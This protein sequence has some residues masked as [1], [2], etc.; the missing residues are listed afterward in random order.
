M[1]PVVEAEKPQKGAPFLYRT[2]LGG[3]VLKLVSARWVSA[4]AGRYMD[5][6]F[7]RHKIKRFIKKHGIIMEDFLPQKYRSFND[8]FTRRIR[9]ELRPFDLSPA[10]LCSPCDGA[11]TVFPVTEGGVFT[12]KGF[13]YTVASLLKNNALAKKYEGG[14]C[15]VLRLTVGDYHRYHFLDGGTAEESV[16]LKG[17][18]HT[19]QP[20]ALEKR[21]VFTEN[22]R[23]YTVLHTENFGDVTE[24]EVGAM[25]VG[26]IVNEGKQTFARGEEKGRFE[27]GGSTVILLFEKGK[28]VPDEELVSNTAAGLETKVKCGERIGGKAHNILWNDLEQDTNA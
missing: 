28:I 13:G 19:V 5:S 21:R 10:A 4:L 17:K 20:T 14:V 23:E 27:F 11:V 8:F 16:Y 2:R 7:S 1:R 3:V 22:C 9:P 25:F 18:L 6:R 15:V 26:R 24:V 12:V